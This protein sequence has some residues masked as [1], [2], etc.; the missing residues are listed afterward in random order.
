MQII[1]LKTNDAFGI[2]DFVTALGF[3]FQNFIK[4]RKNFCKWYIESHN[5][6]INKELA[7]LKL[8][9]S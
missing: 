2:L 6:H 5:I 8:V 7:I 1:F 3:M 9:K 4:Y